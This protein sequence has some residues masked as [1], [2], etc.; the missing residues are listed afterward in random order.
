[1]VPPARCDLA[2]SSR[3][4]HLDLESHEIQLKL[5]DSL[6]TSTNADRTTI[7]ILVSGESQAS[8]LQVEL[9]APAVLI[10]GNTKQPQSLNGSSLH[11]DWTLGFNS[12]GRKIVSFVF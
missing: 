6:M 10:S 5:I 3:P 1:M 9:Q 4:I 7:D 12:S 2:P 8:A 11:Y